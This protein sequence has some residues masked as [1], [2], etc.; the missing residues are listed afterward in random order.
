MSELSNLEQQGVTRDQV[1]EAYKKFVEEG[2]TSPDDLDLNDSEVIEANNLFD[3]WAAGQDPDDKRL[4]F[5][6]TKLYVDAGFTDLNYL[7]NV[8]S[9][10]RQDAHNAEKSTDDP[11]RIQLRQDMAEEIKKIR[12]LLK[13]PI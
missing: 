4:N 13:Q 7:E 9:W 12:G 11:V 6:K 8:L 3:K 2:I 10:L 1:I 5:E